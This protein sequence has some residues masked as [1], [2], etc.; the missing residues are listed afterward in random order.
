M[1]RGVVT[2]AFVAVALAAGMARGGGQ[3]LWND[4]W[5]PASR[6]PDYS[7]AGYHD[8]QRP[9]PDVSVVTSVKDHGAKGDGATDDTAAFQEAIRSVEHGGGAVLVPAGRYVLGDTVVI[10]RPNVVLRGEGPEKT[11]LVVPKSLQQL[12]P[13]GLSS[14][15]KLGYAFGGGFVVIR[16]QVKGEKL[17]DVAAEAKRGG[18]ELVLSAAANVKPGDVVRLLMNNAPSLGRYLHGDL[19]DSG[20]ATA[21]HK[22][23]V[24]FTAQVVSVDGAKVALDRPLRTDVRA[25][26]KPEL[27]S[28]RPTVSESGI[29]RLSFEFPGVPKKKHLQEEGFNA[30]QVSGAVDC[31]VRD[32]AVTD[33]DIGVKLDGARNCTVSGVVVKAVKRKNPTGHHALWASG[34]AQDCLFDHFDIQTQFVHDLSV[35]GFANGNVFARGKGVA[36]NLDH[37]RN[38]PYGN[39]FAELHTGSVSRL[40]DSSGRGDRGPHT[41]GWETVWDLTYDS[42]KLPKLPDWPLLNVVGVKGYPERTPTD[43]TPL[44]EMSDKTPVPAN[45]YEA[46]LRQRAG[47]SAGSR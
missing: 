25:E 30:I 44:V 17:A 4:Q 34:H 3:T 28:Y 35:E 36:L 26:W 9:I 27:W 43:N 5:T 16:G 41:A 46:Q 10:D 33:G 39:L 42:G 14:D 20:V 6:L 40:W 15:E 38:G 37:H 24:D 23:F 7:Y 31:W 2:A 19:F 45:L 11:V 1:M 29:E 12:H 47:A 13:V 21:S 32:I 18:R 8:G 22:N